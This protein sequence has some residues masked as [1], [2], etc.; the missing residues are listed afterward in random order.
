MNVPPNNP[1]RESAN[2]LSQAAKKLAKLLEDRRRG[3]SP[4]G[5]LPPSQGK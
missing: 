2:R 4:L 5:P 3:K 1:H